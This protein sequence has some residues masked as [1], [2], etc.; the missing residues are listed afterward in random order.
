MGLSKGAS[1]GGVTARPVERAQPT[2]PRDQPASGGEP[3]S[4]SHLF[5]NPSLNKFLPASNL[6]AG[7][8]LKTPDG[9]TAVVVG[10]TIPKVHDGWMWD[11]SV[12]GNNDHDFYVLATGPFRMTDPAVLVHNINEVSCPSFNAA[13]RAAFRDNN[14]PTSQANN[15]SVGESSG[16][17]FT[18]NMRGPYGELPQSIYTQ[19][20]DGNPVEIQDHEWGHVFDDTGEEMGPHLKGPDN[21]HYFYPG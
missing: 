18:P 10:G 2:A 1:A 20:L 19:D 13:R 15:Y 5:W 9:Q 11:L 4:S 6:K 7:I 14:V 8:H 17:P 16:G 12:P 3:D 21:T